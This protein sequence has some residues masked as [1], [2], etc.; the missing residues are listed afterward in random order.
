MNTRR[1]SKA[2]SHT[3]MPLVRKR[4]FLD[5]NGRNAQDIEGV[6]KIQNMKRPMIVM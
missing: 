2:H 5:P 3:K 4:N 1:W 6:Y